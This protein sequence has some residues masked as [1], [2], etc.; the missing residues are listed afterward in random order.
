MRSL[1]NS[2]VKLAEGNAFGTE[3]SLVQALLLRVISKPISFTFWMLRPLPNSS[4]KIIYII[5]IKKKKRYVHVKDASKTE[6]L[7]HEVSLFKNEHAG[8]TP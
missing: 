5:Y 2:S 1:P 6:L 8:A 4:V 3:R 7:S